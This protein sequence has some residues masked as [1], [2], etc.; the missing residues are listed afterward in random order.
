[1]TKNEVRIPG[2]FEDGAQ[3]SNAWLASHPAGK[4]ILAIPGAAG[5]IR[6]RRDWFATRAGPQGPQSVTEL[7]AT[8]RRLK[9]SKRA[10]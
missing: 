4:E 8:R 1:M 3:Y 7:M 2:Y 9:T 6:H 5:T 10:S